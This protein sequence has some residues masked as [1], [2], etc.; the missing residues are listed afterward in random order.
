[1]RENISFKYYAGRKP[2]IYMENVKIN[3]YYV[4]LANSLYPFSQKKNSL[5]PI[6]FTYRHTLVELYEYNSS[7]KKKRII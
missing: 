1:M 7:K 3:K 6:R 5:Y 2:N 4:G